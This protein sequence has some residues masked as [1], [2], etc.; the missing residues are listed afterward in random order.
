MPQ[1][2]GFRSRSALR[3]TVE[4]AAQKYANRTGEDVEV[5][6]VMGGY[7]ARSRDRGE[8][9]GSRTHLATLTK[10]PIPDGLV[11]GA[12]K[13]AES[14]KQ[15]GQTAAEAAAAARPRVRQPGVPATQPSQPT[16]K[17]DP[18]PHA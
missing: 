12:A 8:P 16:L 17:T 4:Q 1:P 3:E 14:A 10:Q 9:S 15:P 6:G 13:T 18:A 5:F 2:K 11:D 7:E